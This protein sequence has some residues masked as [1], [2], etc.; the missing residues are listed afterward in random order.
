[1][2]LVRVLQ[3]SFLNNSLHE[4]GAIVEYDGELGPNLE[5][6]K[7]KRGAAAPVDSDAGD[8]AAADPTVE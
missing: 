8:S 2:A 4:E 3:K 1:M 5:L 7:K 6:V